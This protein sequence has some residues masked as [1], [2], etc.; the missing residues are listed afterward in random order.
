MELVR[1]VAP[2]ERRDDVA[3]LSQDFTILFRCSNADTVMVAAS[4]SGE[5]A[6]CGVWLEVSSDYPAQLAARDVATLSTIV[7]LR[8]VVV[9]SLSQ[10][11][12][13]AD[14]LRALLTN[15]E[16][17]FTNDVAVIRGAFN[18]PAPE[19]PVTVWTYDGALESE[20]IRLTKV[21]VEVT[22]VGELT[23]FT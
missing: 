2:L 21:R 9:E 23:H 3:R 1:V 6:D 20:G 5:L 16:V 10:T 17:N 18:R 14:V 15:E 4:L 11:R 22:D 8:H 7:P 19:P 13:Q 12:E